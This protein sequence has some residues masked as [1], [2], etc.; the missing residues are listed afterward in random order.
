[1]RF[2]GWPAI[3]SAV[4][5]HTVNGLLSGDGQGAQS[6]GFASGWGGIGGLVLA[7]IGVRG[8]ARR[9]RAKIQNRLFSR[10]PKYGPLES[11]T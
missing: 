10:F 3:E 2:S 1:M 9:E 6:T 11:I 4:S 5:A 7:M 8:A